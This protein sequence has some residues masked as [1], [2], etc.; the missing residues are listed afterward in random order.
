MD[1]GEPEYHTTQIAREKINA[2]LS[3]GVGNI[4]YILYKFYWILSLIFIAAV[5]QWTAFRMHNTLLMPSPLQTL[6]AAFKAIQTPGILEDMLLTLRRVGT[7]IGISVAIALPLGYMM[8]YF[9]PFLRFADPIINS[10]R[11]IPIMAWVPLTIVWFG[12]GDAPT[13]FLIAFSA[14]FPILLNTIAAVQDISQEYHNAAKSMGAGNLSLFAHIIIP[15]S[16]PGILTGIRIGTGCGWMS[17]IC[18]EFIATSAGFGHA[19]VQ[20]QVLMETPTLIALMLIAG[21]IGF[22]ID[23]CFLLIGRLAAGWKYMAENGY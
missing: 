3:A 6:E 9:K 13:V 11:L 20:A 15:G 10:M 17:V 19:M 23:R 18:A 7:G 5:W 2:Q 8:G 16:L 12:L 21:L 14:F 4:N 1:K 22:L